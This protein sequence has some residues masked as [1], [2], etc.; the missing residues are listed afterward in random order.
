[1]RQ[2]VLLAGSFLLTFA[3]LA[4]GYKVY[5]SVA[6]N[7][8]SSSAAPSA[9][10]GGPSSVPGSAKTVVV[11][12]NGADYDKATVQMV[13]V[14]SVTPLPN[15]SVAMQTDRTGHGTLFVSWKAPSSPDLQPG[16]VAR[17]DTAV[18]GTG[19]GDFWEVYGPTGS[20]EA[21][22]EVVPPS[23]D[24]C[25]HFHNAPGPDTTITVGV[26]LTSILE[27]ERVVYTITL[28]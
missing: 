8:D 25:W 17:I 26:T 21:E 5:V 3:I 9:V 6:G 24:G 4:G 10:G 13:D 15:G 11:T 12:V 16:S 2:V 18:C 22:Y 23:G 19:S 28:R 14:S 27:I 20:D 7:V 1:M